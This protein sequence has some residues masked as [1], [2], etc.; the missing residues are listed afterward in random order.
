MSILDIR[1]LILSLGKH[2]SVGKS[3]TLLLTC[4]GIEMSPIRAMV[5]TMDKRQVILGRKELAIRSQTS[6]AGFQS[7]FPA[8]GFKLAFRCSCCIAQ[9]YQ[10]IVP[11]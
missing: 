9:S 8:R 7:W 2:K 10:V 5:V 6:S 11:G 3:I 4:V 1:K